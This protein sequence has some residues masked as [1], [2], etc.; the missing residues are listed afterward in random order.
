[1]VAFTKDLIAQRIISEG[2]SI[3]SGGKDYLSH[4]ALTERGIKIALATGL[5][6]SNLTM[7]ANNGDPE[8]LNFPHDAISYDAN[9]VGVFQQRAPWWGTVAERM[10]PTLSAAMFY[11]RLA[12]MSYNDTSRSPGSFA[13]AVQQS[14]F[15]TRYDERYGDAEQLY[16]RL[17]GAPTINPV[18]RVGVPR[19]NVEFAKRIGLDRVGNDYVYG[20]N[21]S[22]TDVRRGTDC[23]GLV[24]DICDAVRNG[25]NMAWS[26]H[27]MSTESWRPIEVGQ[28]GTIFNTVCVASPRDFP[29]D[30]V[31]KIAIHHGPG[32]GANSH[33]W[34][35]V[36]GIRLESNGSDGCV[37]GS[38][39]RSVYDTSYAN[40][41][42]YLPGP[43]SD[44]TAT[45]EELLMSDQ[46]YPSVSIYAT[47]GEGPRYTLAQLIQ[48]IDG[49]R[50]RETVETD[51]KL[52]DQDALAR[53]VRVAA[54]RGAYTD[55]GSIAHAKSV[56]ASIEASNPDILQQ[57]LA[58]KNG[59][60]A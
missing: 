6:E 3:R 49:M 34:C 50:H 23:S 17:S 59:A 54:G 32:G 39:A 53:I 20:G 5:V 46:L 29:P 28:T 40:D 37:T 44:G 51:A 52:G 4:P 22:P 15:P 8:S 60:V 33:T 31:V 14:A 21:W 13:Q 47:P 36:D 43:I 30:A 58:S 12:R 2:R 11:N 1:M 26:R 55:A 16:N 27:G 48:S 38:Q 9:S 41:W 42:H 35:E 24:V 25:T 45:I 7:Y 10:D 57:F 18:L 56:L 19:A